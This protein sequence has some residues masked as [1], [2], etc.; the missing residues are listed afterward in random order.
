VTPPEK[1][2]AQNQTAP[3]ATGDPESIAGFSLCLVPYRTSLIFLALM[4]QDDEP[5]ELGEVRP[6]YAPAF[7]GPLTPPRV[8]DAD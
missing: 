3:S 7:D 2:S 4:V 6:G 1:R 8:T 5:S